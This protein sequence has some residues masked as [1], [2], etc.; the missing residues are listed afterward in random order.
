MK[1][2]FASA[3]RIR[4]RRAFREKAVARMDSFGAGLEAGGDN[5]VDREIGLG[6]G[7]RP[8][9]DRLIRHFDVQRVLVRVGINGDGPNAH[10]TRRL[11]DATGDF[12]AVGDQDCLE[13][14]AL[15]RKASGFPST[16]VSIGTTEARKPRA[17]TALLGEG[18]TAFQEQTST[19]R[20]AFLSRARVK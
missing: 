11:D 7:R 16:A 12:A 3:K 9:G 5:F 13:H 10:A 14:R 17:P 19:S 8:D 4:E 15:M 18:P 20:Q 2:I 6:R 1:T